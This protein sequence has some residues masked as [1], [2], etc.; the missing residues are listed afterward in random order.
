MRRI[1][2]ILLIV[3]LSVIPANTISAADTLNNPAYVK[4]PSGYTWVLGGFNSEPQSNNIVLP[5]KATITFNSSPGDLIPF[6]T[7]VKYTLWQRSGGAWKNI[8]TRTYTDFSGASFTIAP[9]IPGTYTFQI[10]ADWAGVIAGTYFSKVFSV[11]ATTTTIPPTVLRLNLDRDTI[12]PGE[13]TRAEVI[14]TPANATANVTWSVAP[15]GIVTIDSQSGI[16]TSQPNKT[17]RVTITA[18]T[19]K[20]SASTQLLVGG[21]K[22]QTVAAG[23]LATFELDGLNESTDY[24]FK[25]YNID[26][27]GKRTAISGATHSRY[28]FTTNP[29]PNLSTNPDQNRLF[30][31]E[32]IPKGRFSSADHIWSNIA[33]LTLTAPRPNP[34]PNIV[35][36]PS[37]ATAPINLSAIVSQSAEL[38]VEASDQLAVADAGH[39]ND[40]WQLTAQLS[41]LQT[42]E[43]SLSAALQLQMGTNQTALTAGGE[44]VPVVRQPRG[45]PFS[46]LLTDA[47]LVIDR[48]PFASAGVYYATLTWR[49]ALIPPAENLQPT[50]KAA[51]VKS[52]SE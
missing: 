6:K 10:Q 31:V 41:T 22:N 4:P 16:I 34:E 3:W 51:T 18:T 35:S 13:S 23:D 8:Q 45:T 24:T 38:P 33:T 29:N 7:S 42:N 11:N 5:N 2:L 36:V 28:Q 49:L 12:L 20:L 9:T 43:T 1:A 39:G 32:L 17:G 19:G 26:A 25:W 44:A 14:L 40:L 21:V 27:A 37:L 48:D 50:E 52:E 46:A 30:Q 47:T 15:A